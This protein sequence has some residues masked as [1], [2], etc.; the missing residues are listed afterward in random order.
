MKYTSIKEKL[1]KAIKKQGFMRTS[2]VIRWG[3]ENHSNTAPRKARL[4]ANEGKIERMDP[5]T[6]LWLFGKIK[7]E[8]WIIKQ[9]PPYPETNF[10]QYL[11]PKI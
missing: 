11:E 7:E 1:F 4:L 10:S 6:K 3:I 9:N 8:V 5:E 2:S